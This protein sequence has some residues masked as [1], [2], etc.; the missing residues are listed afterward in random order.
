LNHEEPNEYRLSN[1]TTDAAYQDEIPRRAPNAYL[2]GAPR[3]VRQFNPLS[4][5]R[6]PFS[7]LML[8]LAFWIALNLNSFLGSGDS[9]E[10]F[11]NWTQN[12]EK[13][14]REYFGSGQIATY[15]GVITDS[16]DYAGKNLAGE[17][18]T[19]LESEDIPFTSAGD[20]PLAIQRLYDSYDESDCSALYYD[21]DTYQALLAAPKTDELR[22][23]YEVV[24]VEAD[25][26]LD[27][28]DCAPA[29]SPQGE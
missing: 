25:S 15:E 6:I 7:F 29:V 20:L 26:R 11:R 2:E 17:I 18:I 19:I 14:F 24:L 3:K 9:G 21:L 1:E 28:L 23:Y 13:S 10:W 4:I 8:V 22:A 27:R 12:T 5:I 16:N